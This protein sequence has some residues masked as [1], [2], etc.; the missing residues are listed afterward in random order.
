[1]KLF[2]NHT[3]N[4][5]TFVEAHQTRTA[6]NYYANYTW[7]E[8]RDVVRMAKRQ[9]RSMGTFPSP[10]DP[11]RSDRIGQTAF[12]VASSIVR[13][14]MAIAATLLLSFTSTLSFLSFMA[15]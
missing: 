15:V 13:N 14:P 4:D 5:Q 3:Q 10:F 6:P 8:P 11:L 7:V 12:N 9:T 1:M 2:A